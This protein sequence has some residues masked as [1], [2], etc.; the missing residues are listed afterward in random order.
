MSLTLGIHIGHDG[1]AALCRDGEVL[2][3]CQEERLTRVKY[4]NG[5]WHSLRY[6]LEAH[7][8]RL[9]DCDLI[10]FS[11]AGPRLPEGYDAG[12]GSWSENLPPVAVLDHHLSH[13]IGAF[14]FSPFDEAMVFVGDAGG[15]EGM[16]ESAFTM[17][18]ARWSKIGGSPPGRPRAGGLGTTYEAF[19]NFLGFRD[20][21]S[22]KTMALAAYGDADALSKTSLFSVH[23][24]GSVWSVLEDPHHWGV[25]AFSGAHA[26]FLGTAFPD[27]RSQRAADIA[28]YIQAEFTRAMSEVV[29]AL[30]L[31]ERDPRL[32][33]S[34]GI[35]LNCVTNQFLSSYLGGDN[36]YAFPVCSDAGLA[37]GNSLYGQWCCE[38]KLP[39]PADASFR[40]GRRYSE[41]ALLNALARHPDTVP[42]GALRRGDLEW[43]Q[44]S[45]PAAQAA[46]YLQEGAV[47]AWWQGRSELGPRALGGR[48]LLADPARAGIR[49][50]L[51]SKV[52]EREWFRPLAPTILDRRQSEFLTT[53]E[54]YPYMNMAPRVSDRGEMLIP[55]A[56]HVD[57]T[58]RVQ[59]ATEALAPEIYS[60]LAELDRRGKTAAVVNTSFNIQE[61][62][63]ESPGDAIATFL[64]S[65]I[66]VLIIEDFVCLRRTHSPFGQ[67]SP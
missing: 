41:T 3:A 53:S 20:Q 39:K 7:N 40:F 61:P 52:K 66:D 45:N 14:C 30:R 50:S 60:I 33:L 22:G 5:W 49:N 63:V 9:S 51:N 56:T 55:E 64:R 34:G 12:L 26:S 16:T 8:L 62:I 42:P 19:T 18:R 43:Q 44:V 31:R 21:E 32:V 24:D 10:V 13:A 28:A 59:V 29:H 46:D 23:S 48:S 2:I 47:V 6:C 27:H 17:D 37:L 15:N 1:G 57:G 58:A 4:A 67:P 25:A 38:G 54:L 35:G 36:F 11:N 65:Q